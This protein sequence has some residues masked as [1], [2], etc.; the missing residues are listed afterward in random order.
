MFT[1]VC[2]YMLTMGAVDAF[3][4]SKNHPAIMAFSNPYHHHHHQQQQMQCHNQF[5]LYSASSSSEEEFE[6][7]MNR[8]RRNRNNRSNDDESEN[9]AHIAKPLL[10]LPPIGESSYG[11]IPSA[12]DDSQTTI[13]EATGHK[14]ITLNSEEGTKVAQVGSS[15]FEL[16][17]TCNI[18]ETRNTHK[19]SRLGKFEKL[20]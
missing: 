7:K 14:K 10:P 5:Q 17:Y 1:V 12:H 18:C 3:S 13:D 19:V 6:D 4:N 8:R 15:K 11:S 2:G 9:D 20:S 16:Q